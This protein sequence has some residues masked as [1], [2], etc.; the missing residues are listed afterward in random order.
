[1]ISLPP[2]REI[3]GAPSGRVNGA[4]RTRAVSEPG[5]GARVGE[6]FRDADLSEADLS[7]ADLYNDDLSGANLSG[8]RQIN[9]DAFAQIAPDYG[10]PLIQVNALHLDRS[11]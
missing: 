3:R 8:A 5:R 11:C 9:L 2:V 6:D 1:V 4:A 7:G 10:I